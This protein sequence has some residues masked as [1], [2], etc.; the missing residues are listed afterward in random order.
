MG[1]AVKMV[2]PARTQKQLQSE[3]TRQRI[4]QA[5]AE[6]FVR[7]GFAGTS[8]AD[9]AEATDL[10]KG[11]LYHHFSSKSALFF[12]VLEMVR[13]SWAEAVVRDVLKTKKAL[14]RLAV[15]LDNHTRLVSKNET[16]CLV[17]ASLVGETDLEDKG[18]K[19]ADALRA[20]YGDLVKFIELII[21]KGQ[22]SGEIRPDLDARATALNVVGMMRTTCCSV[23]NQYGVSFSRRMT[24]LR[25][26]FIDGLRG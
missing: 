8:I 1:D 24:T 16:V 12:A 26:I 2:V 17:M 3:Q 7:K 22:A 18:S 6:L 19:F 23:L 13:T 21:R 11:A 10:T 5:T 25:Q 20:L 14:D 9:I 15:L 4:V